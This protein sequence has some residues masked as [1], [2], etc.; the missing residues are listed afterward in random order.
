M[1]SSTRSKAN[2]RQTLNLPPGFEEV[3]VDKD[4]SIVQER[5]NLAQFVVY[6]DQYRNTRLN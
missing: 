3:R 5:D 6:F 2:G 1:L 4:L